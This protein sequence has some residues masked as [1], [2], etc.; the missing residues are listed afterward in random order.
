MGT[1]PSS[2]QSRSGVARS[3]ADYVCTLP[4]ASGSFRCRTLVR[5]HLT[6]SQ[7]GPVRNPACGQDQQ[8]TNSIPFYSL[9]A[10][11]SAPTLNGG[12]D[13]LLWRGGIRISG[14]LTHGEC[15]P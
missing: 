5:V 2:C 7:T 10:L 8:W 11:V 6:K 3:K 9:Q 13:L 1:T 12:L 15:L 14:C 4:L